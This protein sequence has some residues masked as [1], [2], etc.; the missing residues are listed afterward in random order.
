MALSSCRTVLFTHT[1]FHDSAGEGC[2]VHEV[3]FSEGRFSCRSQVG[4]AGRVRHLDTVTISPVSAAKS[5]RLPR[6]RPKFRSSRWL[7]R[8]AVAVGRG[9][10]PALR[11]KGRFNAA[12]YRSPIVLRRAGSVV[13]GT[14][15]GET[16]NPQLGQGEDFEP[17]RAQRAQGEAVFCS[18][19]SHSPPL[20]NGLNGFAVQLRGSVLCDPCVLCGSRSRLLPL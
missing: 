18:L 16:R 19:R 3:A 14:P 12:A 1:A 15:R 5:R 4:A 7:S 20:S 6:E 2:G 11:W 13:I 10:D 9:G 17:Q 8:G